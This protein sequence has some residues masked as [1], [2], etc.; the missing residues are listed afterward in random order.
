MT[1]ITIT[2]RIL[3]GIRE[4]REK[5]ASHRD[6]AR[7]FRTVPSGLGTSF[8][9]GLP[10]KWWAIFAN[11]GAAPERARRTMCQSR[12]PLT[13]KQ[14]VPCARLLGEKVTGPIPKPA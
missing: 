4:G 1:V 14:A 3:L 13:M 11:P 7:A 10:L 12:K 2:T 6:E 8:H 9:P 5:H